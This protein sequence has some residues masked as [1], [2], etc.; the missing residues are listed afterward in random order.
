MVATYF[1]KDLKEPLNTCSV[2]LDLN[3]WFRMIWFLKNLA[4]PELDVYS[5]QPFLRANV[6]GEAYS[7][8][9]IFKKFWASPTLLH[10]TYV[11]Y[12]LCYKRLQ[13]SK[14]RFMR[15]E[16]SELPMFAAN[17]AW[18]DSMVNWIWLFSSVSIS[19]TENTIWAIAFRVKLVQRLGWWIG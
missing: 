14:R 11:F 17:M 10:I 15:S 3:Y 13:K 4:F 19:G 8:C 16:I 6:G 1:S 5:P 7:V 9:L 18:N 12:F 2:N